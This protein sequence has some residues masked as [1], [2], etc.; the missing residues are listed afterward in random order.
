MSGRINDKVR[1]Y[2]FLTMIAVVVNIM[3]FKL[4]VGVPSAASPLSATSFT[5]V[6]V[7]QVSGTETIT[8]T[9][10]ATIT[11]ASIPTSTVVVSDGVT[12]EELLSVYKDLVESNT[13]AVKTAHS[14]LTIILGLVTVV[15]G[16]LTA[17][18]AYSAVNARR[19]NEAA[20]KAS[21]DVKELESAKEQIQRELEALGSEKAQVE[22]EL[23]VL[24]SRLDQSLEDLRQLE[25]SRMELEWALEEQRQQIEGDVR[26]LERLHSL[27]EVDRYAMEFFGDDVRRRE[28]GKKGLLYLSRNDDPIIRRECLRVFA[29]MPEY[30]D[31]WADEQ[32]LDRIT[33]M[34]K[35][36]GERGVRK[37]AEATR[38]EWERLGG[39]RLEKARSD[40]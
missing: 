24:N 29:V 15:S 33:S 25:H 32:I 11:T 5:A 7:V 17:T 21:A 13:Q 22:E 20:R 6:E 1:K 8:S 3:A 23:E 30:L 36:D 10:P 37:E 35:T 19:A 38:G 40:D 34:M 16:A 31:D 18:G 2:A 27:A 39:K 9:I 28:A 12:E 26:I 4:S 14:T